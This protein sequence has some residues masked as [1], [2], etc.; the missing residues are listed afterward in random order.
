MELSELTGLEVSEGK[1]VI[2]Q[3]GYSSRIVE[4]DGVPYIG[5]SDFDMRRVKLRVKDDIIIEAY[6]G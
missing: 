5:T 2:R 3:N 6:L 4:N 1:C